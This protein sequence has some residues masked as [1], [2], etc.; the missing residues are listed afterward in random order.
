MI[1][2][3]A[4]ERDFHLIWTAPMSPWTV[5]GREEEHTPERAR[6]AAQDDGVM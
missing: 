5:Q 3:A 4:A 6:Q 2:H 1:H